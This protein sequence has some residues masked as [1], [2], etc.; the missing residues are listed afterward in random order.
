[1]EIIEYF[2]LPEK[3]KAS[4]RLYVNQIVEQANAT[5]NDKKLLEKSIKSF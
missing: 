2:K 1:M 5:G 4:Q 3:A